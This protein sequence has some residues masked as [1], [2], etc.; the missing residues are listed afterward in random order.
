[1]VRG[2]QLETFNVAKRAAWRRSPGAAWSAVSDVVIASIVMSTHCPRDL[3]LRR[4]CGE[5]NRC[6]GGSDDGNEREVHCASRRIK[7]FA[8]S[9]RAD[10]SAFPTQ[11][12]RGRT[13]TVL[14]SWRKEGDEELW[15]LSAGFYRFVRHLTRSLSWRMY[16]RVQAL[17]H[18]AK[19]KLLA[20]CWRQGLHQAR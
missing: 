5:R 17:L 9:T 18:R 15:W 6:H 3:H 7:R 19:L 4:R 10:H 1:M 14:E 8:I 13:R 16:L 12:N 2:P 20:D 11:L